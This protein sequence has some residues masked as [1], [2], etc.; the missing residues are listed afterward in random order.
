MSFGGQRRPPVVW[1]YCSVCKH[2]RTRYPYTNEC[3]PCYEQ[4]RRHGTRQGC[5]SI[6]QERSLIASFL[7]DRGHPE[8]AALIRTRAYL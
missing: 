8:L 1:N 5:K 2:R 7:D 6:Q 3:G 4:L